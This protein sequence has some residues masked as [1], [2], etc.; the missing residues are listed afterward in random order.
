MKIKHNC[1]KYGYTLLAPTYKLDT[2]EK[3]NK[4]LDNHI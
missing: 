4:Y 2:Q 1:N 3:I